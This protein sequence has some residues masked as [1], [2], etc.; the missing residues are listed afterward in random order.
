MSAVCSIRLPLDSHCK[1]STFSASFL[2]I[3]PLIL[4]S[5]FSV[6][7]FIVFDLSLLVLMII[8]LTLFLCFTAVIVHALSAHVICTAICMY[9]CHKLS[10]LI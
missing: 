7:V 3:A 10:E 5:S 8:S 6:E 2:S 1:A 4:S 9:V